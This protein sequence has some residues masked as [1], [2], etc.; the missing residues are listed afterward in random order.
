MDI[1]S[2]QI[3][4]FERFRRKKW[5]LLIYSSVLAAIISAPAFGHTA[6]KPVLISSGVYRWLCDSQQ[7]SCDNQILRIDMMYTVMS[8]VVNAAG[9]PLGIFV[10]VYG[11]RTSLILGV[12][13]TGF[14]SALFAFAYRFS[15]DIYISAYNIF[16]LGGQLYYLSVA[17][18]CNLF[19]MNRQGVVSGLQ[20]A[21]G[22][23][24]SLLF[25]AFQALHFQLGSTLDS[26]FFG[27]VAI[28]IFLLPP[29]FFLMPTRSVTLLSN[30]T[31]EIAHAPI[32][33]ESL[34]GKSSMIDQET[35]PAFHHPPIT[36]VRKYKRSRSDVDFSNLLPPADSHQPKGLWSAVLRDIRKLGWGE[37]SLVLVWSCFTF[38]AQNFFLSNV[39]EQLVWVSGGNIKEAES[40]AHMFAVLFPLWG[41][42]GCNLAG[43][44]LDKLGIGW[45]LIVM[46]CLNITYC[47]LEMV[48]IVALQQVT[49][50]SATFGRA[51]YWMILYL[52]LRTKLSA[53]TFTTILGI[54]TLVASVT[55]LS[56]YLAT[57]LAEKV[58][59]GKFGVIDIAIASLQ[60]SSGVAFAI[61][62]LR[63][64]RKS[65][66]VMT[67]HDSYLL[68]APDEPQ[69]SQR[70]EQ[71][72]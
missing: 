71:E 42:V 30:S 67:N 26:L 52:Y 20:M 12:V 49:F 31:G 39:Y 41:I 40:G 5:A 51:F 36:P 15:W 61:R 45:S 63:N 58:L 53:E 59:G 3:D 6:L 10:D 37:F 1:A 56:G 46:V 50:A 7:Q 21:A 19:P 16:A 17:Q 64:E 47:I 18:L 22:E 24:S 8:S 2:D 70:E 72:P 9:L 43:L 65:N 25:T 48:P 69:S 54:V 68:I 4:P 55:N 14:G 60:I 33:L 29:A 62:C 34:T 57:Y 23:G 32:E 44:F 28:C 35:T 27:L 38:I 66:C 13:A 11:P